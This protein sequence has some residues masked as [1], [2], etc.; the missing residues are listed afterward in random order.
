MPELKPD[1]ITAKD[2]LE[3]LSDAS[4]FEF[5]LRTL[6][7][8]RSLGLACEHGGLYDDPVTKK[9][10]QFDIRAIARAEQHCVRLAVEC[11]NIGANF[12]LLV[13]RV[14]R[15]PDE[16]FHDIAIAGY[17]NDGNQMYGMY[18]SRAHVMRIEDS[19]SIYRAH[20]PVGKSM[21]R[22]GREATKK[23]S[24]V[25]NDQDV[26]DRWAQSLASAHDLVVD[27]YWEG[28]DDDP[29]VSYVAIL[30]MVV[31]PDGRLWT[32]DYDANGDRKND[33]TPTDQCSL[34]V[35]H[36]Y[37]MDPAGPWLRISH[38]EFVTFSRLAAFVTDC[39]KDRA[40]M[41]SIFPQET[42]RSFE[43]N[44]RAGHA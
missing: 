18:R 30:P 44:L 34:F 41:E 3:Y 12:P 7:L 17:I 13:S 2:L 19:D 14:P 1:A 20:R 26:F 28:S 24:I 11:K 31:V 16:S 23:S 40:A 6:K 39:L 8:L 42:V 9:P 10:R 38:V 25:A 21:A 27:S 33:P 35:N 29:S 43:N 15:H 37:R 5:E 32:V 36:G 4:D 22:I